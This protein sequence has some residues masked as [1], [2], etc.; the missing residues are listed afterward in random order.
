MSSEPAVIKEII[1]PEVT[2][3]LKNDGITYVFFK[4]NCVLDVTLQLRMLDIYNEIT[5]KKLTPFIFEADEGLI[6]T[7]EARDNAITIEESSP[8]KA[9]AVVVTNIAYALIANF[10]MKFNKPKRPYKVFS[11]RAEALEWLKGYL[12]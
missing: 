9:M 4:K 12:E 3:S 10:Y 5:N 7:K 8:C 6:V 1:L 2:I 11:K